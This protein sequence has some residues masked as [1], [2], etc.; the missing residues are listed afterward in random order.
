MNGAVIVTCAAVGEAEVL[1]GAEFLDAGKDV[2]PAA[3][4]EAG[5]VLA[6][7]VQDLVHLERREHRL[8]E[9]GGLDRALRDSQLALAEKLKMSFHSR[10]SRCDSI[11]GR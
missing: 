2:V 7:L 3:D 11:F 5:R 6:Q 9:R 8:D 4:V 1:V 10:A